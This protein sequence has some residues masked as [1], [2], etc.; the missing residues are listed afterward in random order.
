M[1]KEIIFLFLAL[2]FTSCQDFLDEKSKSQMTEDYYNTENG[3]YSGV[4]SVYSVC[5]ELY[6]EPM[7][8][9][10]Y[11][12]DLVENASSMNV[13][14]DQAANVGWGTLND[15]FSAIHKGIMIINRLENI[16]GENPGDRTKEIYLAELRFLR[17][18]FYQIQVEVWGRY[19]HFQ[20][21]VYNEFDEDMLNINQKSVE[22]FYTQ[23]LEDIDFAIEKLPPKSEI[24][25]IGRVS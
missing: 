3:L 23:I 25:E 14:Y 22:F 13:S 17:A 10:N 24:K 7:F 2:F 8:R 15:V 5:R 11:Y 20:E 12:G 9:L 16:I 19:G 1:K 6:R 21:K 18:H 4:A